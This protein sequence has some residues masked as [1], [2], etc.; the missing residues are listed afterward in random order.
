MDTEEIAKLVR[1]LKLSKEAKTM[2]ITITP[3]EEKRGQ[4]RI[5]KVIVGKIFAKKTVNKETLR[6]S[7]PRILRSRGR[8][9]IE[10]VGHNLF[11]ASFSLAT[12]KR[13]AL[14]EGPWHYF[15]DLMILKE[16]D[17]MQTPAD[18]EFNEIT[19]WVQCHNV[20]MACM[21]AGIIRRL[22]EKVGTVE[23]VDV[24]EEGL[25]LGKFARVRVTRRID[26]PLIRC[27]PITQEHTDREVLAILQYERLPQF[28][29]RCGR[30]GHI[31]KECEDKFMDDTAPKYDNWLR[32]GRSMAGWAARNTS[33]PSNADAAS[34]RAQERRE[35][36]GTELVIRREEKGDS[37]EGITRGGTEMGGKEMIIE[38]E[39]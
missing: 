32:A 4:Q 35:N 11:V 37:E 7:L 3:E 15:Q 1:E 27:I 23:E 20:P 8:T 38:V 12:D 14:E 9:K 33:N 21:E 10:M 39:E 28:C 16:T 17:T 29:F 19:M 5:E 22:G 30:I 2:T 6:K 34:S 13:I 36:V 25:C 26:E 18:V 31:S 24:G